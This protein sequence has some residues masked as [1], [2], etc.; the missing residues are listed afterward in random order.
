MIEVPGGYRGFVEGCKIPY[1]F[2]KST[3]TGQSKDQIHAGSFHDAMREAGVEITNIIGYTSILP[4]IAREIPLEEG[5]DRLIHGAELKTIKAEAHVDRELGQKRA[6]TAILYG[7]LYPKNKKAA[8]HEGGLVC[9]YNG[10]GTVEEA[11]ENVSNCI[12]VLFTAKNRRG[13]AFSENYEL[14]KAPPLTATIEPKLQFG[15]AFCVIGFVSYVVPIL[16][17][18]IFPTD[19]EAAAVFSQS[20]FGRKD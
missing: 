19:A 8:K 4:A 20:A 17:Q 11:L 15:T 7:W 9:E 3:G 14:R 10:Q 1:E 16:G 6:T 5:I 13:V 18:N 2:F 12:K